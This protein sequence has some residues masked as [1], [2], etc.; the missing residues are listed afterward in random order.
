MTITLPLRP[1]EAAR[2]NA[3]AESKGVSPDQLVLE[4][5]NLVL[6]DSLSTQEAPKVQARSIWEVML[7][8][9]KNI[10]AEEFAALPKDGASEHD[11]Y[12]YRTQR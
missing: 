9:L 4:A 2:L 12:L 8:N 11:H 10:P 5:L 1:Q 7:D 6:D 3:I